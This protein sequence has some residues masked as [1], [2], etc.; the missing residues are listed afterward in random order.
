MKRSRLQATHLTVKPGIFLHRKVLS[1]FR[2]TASAFFHEL[3]FD[4]AFARAFVRLKKDLIQWLIGDEQHLFRR[5]QVRQ[6]LEFLRG[7]KSN[8]ARYR[9]TLKDILGRPE[10]RFH[11]KKLVLDWLGALPD[12]TPDEWHIVEELN[13]ELGEHMWGIISNSV[14]WFNTL[15]GMGRWQVWLKSDDDQINRALGLLRMPDV[16]DSRS[17]VIAGLIRENRDT[18]EAWA[19]RL[20]WLIAGRHGYTSPEM[21]DLVVELIGDGTLDQVRPGIAGSDDWWFTW[22]G[23]GTQQPEFAI[24]ILGAWFDRQTERTA[25][26]GHPNPFALELVTHSQ[27]SDDLIRECAKTAPLQFVSEL[28]PRFARLDLSV[29]KEWITAPGRGHKPD[30]QLRDALMDA[31]C[32][33]ASEDPAA[34]DAIV[35]AASHGESKWMSA[36]LLRAWSTNPEAYT[37]RIVRFILASPNRRLTI[38]YNIAASG[39]DSLAAVSRI[40][41]VAASSRC[42]DESFVNLERAILSL[43]LDREQKYRVVGRTALSL[44]RALDKTRL[45]ASVRRRIQEL[46]RTLPGRSRAR[47]TSTTSSE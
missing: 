6:V 1:T 14:P 36:L 33:V 12:P 35:D 32:T 37:D 2:V 8:G 27:Y 44:L 16:L 4:Y 23:L 39:T 21:H 22:Y 20:Q 40:A 5:S 47:C 7:Y 19:A 38:G 26:L 24:R 46:E 29:P 45:S 43:S 9:Q 25:A 15:Q 11:I 41:I 34:L 18:S 13:D 17:D 31:M 10:I 3:F 42:S 30:E 28:F